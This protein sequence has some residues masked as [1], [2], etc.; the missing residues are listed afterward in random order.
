MLENMNLLTTAITAL[1]ATASE[2]NSIP[3]ALFVLCELE[4]RPI[5]SERVRKGS[6]V[7]GEWTEV[8]QCFVQRERDGVDIG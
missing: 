2:Y 4:L 5:E 3:L 6:V 8:V 1:L 7:L